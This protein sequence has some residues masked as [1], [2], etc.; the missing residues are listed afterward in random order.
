MPSPSQLTPPVLGSGEQ[1][2]LLR[3]CAGWAAAAGDTSLEFSSLNPST[4]SPP[5]RLL[6]LL[7]K[8]RGPLCLK[9]ARHQGPGIQKPRG[10]TQSLSLCL[11]AGRPRHSACVAGGAAHFFH[12][13][14]NRFRPHRIRGGIW[15]LKLFLSRDGFYLL[16]DVAPGGMGPVDV[17]GGEQQWGLQPAAPSRKPWKEASWLRVFWQHCP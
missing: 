11:S 7:G 16:E 12:D 15:G 17:D 3:R 8:S 14:L 1:G 2:P 10:R 13:I 9:A 4:P 6:M 5:C